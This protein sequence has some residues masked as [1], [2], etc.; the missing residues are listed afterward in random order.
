LSGAWGRL[1]V[2]RRRYGCLHAVVRV[3]T[4]LR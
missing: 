2:G 1:S 3:R 4:G